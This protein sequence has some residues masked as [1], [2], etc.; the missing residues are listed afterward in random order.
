MQ[1]GFT[2]DLFNSEE[3]MNDAEAGS[4]SAGAATFS[5]D[6]YKIIPTQVV[7][8]NGKVELMNCEYPYKNQDGSACTHI[9]RLYARIRPAG[10]G[11]KD[12]QLTLIVETPEQ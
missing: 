6:A 12:F 4:S 1:A 7:A 2:F 8:A 11:E 5:E 3:A 9:R 10:S